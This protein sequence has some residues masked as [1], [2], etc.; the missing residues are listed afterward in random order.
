MYPPIQLTNSLHRKKETFSPLNAPHVGMYVCGVTPYDH[1]HLGHARCYVTFDTLARLLKF[2]GYQVTYVRNY[3][4]IEDKIIAKAV[5]NEQSVDQIATTFITSYQEDM[6][7]LNCLTPDIEPK[8][9]THIPE[10]IAFIEGLVSSGNAYTTNGDVYFD[11]TTHATYGTLSGKKLDDLIAGSRVAVNEQKRNAGDFALWKGNSNR[12]FWDSPW[13]YGR[14]GWHIE[15]SAMA[16]K[17]LGNTVDIHG[18]GMDLMFPHHEN[19]CAQS[20]SLTKKP[21]ANIWLHN[22]FININKEKMSKSLGNAVNL[23][24]VFTSIDPMVLRFY[25]LQH[26][27]RTPLDFE[28]AEF[29]G[30]KTAYKKLCTLNTDAP[31]DAQEH[32]DTKL[33]IGNITGALFD[34]LNT[35]KALGIIFE[36]LSII[37]QHTSLRQEVVNVLQKVLGL[38]LNQLEN[39]MQVT[40]EIALLLQERDNARQNKDWAKADALRTELTKLGYVAQDKKL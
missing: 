27:Y 23:K 8:V 10:I 36:H 40:P 11:I 32:P 39:A 2:A 34:D 9:T 18:G 26:H 20:E 30:V 13:G 21:L 28:P 38:T 37:K 12:E 15:C 33:I 17:H 29:E 35:P 22:A 31:P 25:F 3:T 14:P 19:E 7:K 1:A 16:H 6:A 4:D 5:Q 24:Q